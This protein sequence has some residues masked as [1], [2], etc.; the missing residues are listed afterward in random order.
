MGKCSGLMQGKT[1][2]ADGPPD[3]PALQAAEDILRTIYGDDLKGC[4]VT[5]EQIAAIIGN[6]ARQ[7]DAHTNEMLELYEKLVEAIHLLSTPPD[8]KKVAAPNELSSLLSQRLDAIYA[9]ATRTLETT[10]RVKKQR[11]D[12]P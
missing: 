2:S 8:A 11:G 7:R 4:T 9:L 5:L 12:E 6:A 3:K 10:A 1:M